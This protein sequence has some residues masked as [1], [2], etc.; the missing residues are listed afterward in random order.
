MN[1]LLPL[2]DNNICC[3]VK[4]LL[5]WVKCRAPSL[6]LWLYSTAVR[7]RTSIFGKQ[8]L[9]VLLGMENKVQNGGR[10]FCGNFTQASNDLPYL[11]PHWTISPC[12]RRSL[13]K[14]CRLYYPKCEVTAWGYAAHV[15]RVWDTVSL[16]C[17]GRVPKDACCRQ[18]VML[19]CRDREKYLSLV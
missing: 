16:V 7:F 10:L 9:T 5:I 13:S 19:R 3:D 15:T 18:Y 12:C 6:A 2:Y 8:V 17:T 4:L 1:I 14:V 11:R